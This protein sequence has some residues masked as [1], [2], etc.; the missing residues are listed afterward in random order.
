MGL[1]Q[2]LTAKVYVGAKYR[3]VKQNYIE[4]AD[5]YGGMDKDNADFKDCKL[6]PTFNI[7]H[8]SYDIGYWRKVNWIHK[9]FVDNVQGGNDDCKEYEV[10][11]ELLDKLYST[12]ETILNKFCN[13]KNDKDKLEL[14]DYINDKLPPQSGFFFGSTELKEDDVLDYYRESLYDTMK[15]IRLAKKYIEKFGADIYYQSSW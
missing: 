1:D 7:S 12:C 4:V 10:S 3:A 8:I 5:L 2:Y 13:V 9:W 6:Y 14:I 11:S 15:F